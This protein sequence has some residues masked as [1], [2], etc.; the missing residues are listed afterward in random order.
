VGFTK[1]SGLARRE[2]L[3]LE[4]S[5]AEEGKAQEGGLFMENNDL[6]FFKKKQF[7]VIPIGYPPGITGF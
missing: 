4:P 7:P 6:N 3:F 5:T 1:I 2:P